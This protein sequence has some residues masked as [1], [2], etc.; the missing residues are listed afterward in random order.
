MPTITTLIFDLSEVLIA[1]LVG[2]EH[3]LS[4]RLNLTEAD[5][6]VEFGGDSLTGI[7]RG[8]ISEE[9]YLASILE[10]TGW[11]V[12]GQELQGIIR[13]NFRERVAGMEEMV[14]SLASRYELVL[15]SDH[16]VEWIAAIE[17]MHPFL[18]VFRHRFY[19]FQLQKTKKEPTIFSQVLEVL[20][21]Q[22]EE[23]LFIDDS[24]ANI[25]S[26]AEAGIRGIQFVNAAQLTHELRKINI[27]VD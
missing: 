26:A 20:R 16:A 22:P 9:V 3:A 4:P 8:Q 17:P 18:S 13:D 12:S 11:P 25:A 2:I 24:P 15:L 5:I 21:K 27:V 10:R 23:C 19:S 1:G 14:T 6:L 7:C